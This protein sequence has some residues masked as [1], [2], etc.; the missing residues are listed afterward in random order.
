MYPIFRFAKEMA[1]HA[2]VGTLAL[3]EVHVSHHICWP[4]DIDLWLELNN[5]RTLTLYDLGRL[6]MAYRSG[7][8]SALWRNHWGM[9]VAGASVR[10]RRR[11]KAFQRFTMKSVIL[12][13]D[14][15]FFY[16]QQSMWRDGQATSSLLTRM[17]MTDK[18]G[19]LAP[20]HAARA[21]GWPDTSPALPK[22]VR[23]WIDAEATRPWPPA[24]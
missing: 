17:A 12:G 9:S 5:G 18:K 19:I 21:I 2:R 8:I 15:R 24:V 11:I 1:V 13:W 3:G 14:E 10:Y 6:P 7:M 22:Y 16:F 20:V 4:W 23:A